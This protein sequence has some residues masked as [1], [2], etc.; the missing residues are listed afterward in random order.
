MKLDYALKY[1]NTKTCTGA[2]VVKKRVLN[3][4]SVS[5]QHKDTILS[6]IP[7]DP[8]CR[9][10]RM[11]SLEKVKD[12]TLDALSRI[13]LIHRIAHVSILLYFSDITF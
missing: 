11:R 8:H 5:F 4:I 6:M 3:G 1:N 10:P 9:L 7:Y 2:S 12:T 13:T